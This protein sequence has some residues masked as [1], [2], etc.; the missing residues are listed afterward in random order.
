MK[1]QFL[2]VVVAAALIAPSMHAQAKKE[3]GPKVKVEKAVPKETEAQL[4]AAAKVSEADAAKTA[5]AKVPGSTVKSSELEREDGKLI[6][7][8]DLATKG[9]SGIDEVHV[10]AITGAIVGKVEH[11]NAK[12]EAKEA[13]AEAMEKKKP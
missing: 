13:K 7:S 11:E 8:F 1:S 6:Y 9:K 3:T 4:K 2:M 12:A 10:D 5:L